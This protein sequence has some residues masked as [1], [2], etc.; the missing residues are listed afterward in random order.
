MRNYFDQNFKTKFSTQTMSKQKGYQW[1]IEEMENE[2]EYP[3]NDC[4]TFDG[5]FSMLC[6]YNQHFD[7]FIRIYE[8]DTSKLII[9]NI[10]LNTISELAKFS[11][12]QNTVKYILKNSNYK[13]FSSLFLLGIIAGF[14]EKKNIHGAYDYGMFI[15]K[16]WFELYDMDS[17]SKK[18]KENIEYLLNTIDIK[19]STKIKKIYINNI[20]KI[21][22]PYNKKNLN[23]LKQHNKLF[24]NLKY[25]RIEFCTWQENYLLT[26]SRI[27]LTISNIIPLFSN[28]HGKFPNYDKFNKELLKKLK[29]FFKNNNDAMLVLNIIDYKINNANITE[30]NQIVV[31]NQVLHII[32]KESKPYKYN[33]IWFNILIKYMNVN[34]SYIKKNLSDIYI[35]L[36]KKKNIDIILFLKD[37]G[38]KI[39]YDIKKRINNYYIKRIKEIEKIEVLSVLIQLLQEDYIKDNINNEILSKIRNV[40]LNL[41]KKSERITDEPYSFYCLM[42]F[43]VSVKGKIKD[44]LINKYSF[45]LLELW[46]NEFYQNSIN[47]LQERIYE[48]KIEKEKIIDFN[49]SFLMNPIISLRQNFSWNEKQILNSMKTTSQYAITAITRE[50]TIYIDEFFPY[51]KKLEIYSNDSFEKCL[52]EYIENTQI[53]YEEQLLNSNLTATQYMYPIFEQNNYTLNIFS[54]FLDEK[55]YELMYKDIKDSFLKYE[56]LNYPKENIKV[57][58]V[59]QLI[60]LLELLIRELGIKNNILPFK[61]KQNQIHIM[62]DSSTILQNIIKNKYK[63]NKNFNGSEVYLFLYNNL[64]NVNC[65]NLRNEIIHSRQFIDNPNQIKYAFKIMVLSIFWAS[66]ELSLP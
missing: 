47:S 26:I 50:N 24:N 62:K 46:E 23:Y 25:K 15:Y 6:K 65:L 17:I 20:N 8:I 43:Y 19:E 21:K 2:F 40:F 63:I 13:N 36:K 51:R 39:D 56:L 14:I 4:I 55:T 10:F 11:L 18:R 31:L 66:L 30:K 60:P 12:K 35:E 41:I 45:E 9:K 27:N 49:Q 57:A 28:N 1:V 33:N 44:D 22:Q 32:K 64:Y 52:Y 7:Y 34:N 53:K 48:Q 38:F 16:N 58:D 61:E 54:K 37:N 5:Y 29:D 3:L 42:N 59:T